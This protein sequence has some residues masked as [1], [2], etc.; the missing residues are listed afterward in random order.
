[1]NGSNSSV[2]IVRHRGDNVGRVLDLERVPFAR[3]VAVNRRVG[4]DRPWENSPALAR[5]QVIIV[6]VP[7]KLQHRGGVAGLD[8]V[9]R[10][11]TV[12]RILDLAAIRQSYFL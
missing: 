8:L 9:E 11:V 7:T 3:V 6:V 2:H 5:N 4:V 1:F 10:A 12:V